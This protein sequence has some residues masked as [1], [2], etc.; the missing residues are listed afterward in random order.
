[1]LKLS[2]SKDALK[3]TL[4]LCSKK[5]RLIHTFFWAM[6]QDKLKTFKNILL[7]H[8]LVLSALGIYLEQ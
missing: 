6:W 3:L 7:H 5:N 2:L 4:L 8:Q 1:M